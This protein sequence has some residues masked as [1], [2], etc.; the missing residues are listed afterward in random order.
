[1]AI[2]K[3]YL[4]CNRTSEGD[5]VLTPRYAVLPIL[6]Y[7][8]MKGYKTVWCPFSLPSSKYVKVF[9][10]AGLTVIH[11]HIDEGKDFFEQDVPECDC[12]ID[13]PP[14]SKKDKILIGR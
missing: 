5:E 10:D 9:Q 2:N 7:V 8:L 4:T 3:G 11:G 6:K 13:N 14:F 1:M 12:I